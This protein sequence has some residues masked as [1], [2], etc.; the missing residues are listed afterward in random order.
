VDRLL[1]SLEI[2]GHAGGWA[3]DQIARG[4]VAHAR[5][6]HYSAAIALGQGRRQLA[7]LGGSQVQ[8]QWFDALFVDG[9]AR[10]R[11]GEG[12]RACA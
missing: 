7:R 3:L 9:L 4:V 8:R 10:A 12:A 1:R 2:R 5:G 11:A 6:Q